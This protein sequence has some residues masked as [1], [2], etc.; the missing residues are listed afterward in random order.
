MVG[1]R[2]SQY[3]SPVGEKVR[4]ERLWTSA[5]E[6][7]ARPGKNLTHR[8]LEVIVA[9]PLLDSTRFPL[10]TNAS[11]R[12][13][14]KLPRRDSKWPEDITIDIHAARRKDYD[15][16]HKSESDITDSDYERAFRSIPT[17]LACRA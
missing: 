7:P 6:T 3:Q 4:R 11:I 8:H 15:L 5:G 16:T 10:Q 12:S 14:W 9:A 13:E 17:S 1:H 2:L